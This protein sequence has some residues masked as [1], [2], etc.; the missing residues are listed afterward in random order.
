M[1]RPVGINNREPQIT[2]C[3]NIR[4]GIELIPHAYTI[5]TMWWGV[6]FDLTQI[7]G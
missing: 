2:V 1:D 5:E 7:Q 6:R 4:E 3:R